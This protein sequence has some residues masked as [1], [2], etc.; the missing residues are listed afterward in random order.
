MWMME[1]RILVWRFN[2]GDPSALRQIYEK[3]RKGMMRVATALLDDRS[4][5]EDLVHDVFVRF[6]GTAGRF[7]LTG[8]LKAYLSVC[9][10]NCARDFNR[11]KR[12]RDAQSAGGAEWAGERTDPEA[13]TMQREQGAVID[14]VLAR[15]PEE[16]REVLVLHLQAGL[17]FRRIAAL[18][19]IPINTAMSRYRYG[20]EKIRAAVNRSDGHV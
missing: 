9:V 8:S 14:G 17:P 6:A 10:A 18:M 5:V 13:A 7:E 19:E 12:R 16:Q 20:L 11:S 15:L 4:F 2:R 3:H 1:E